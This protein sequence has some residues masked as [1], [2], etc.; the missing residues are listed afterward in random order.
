[1]TQEDDQWA[2]G[3]FGT[4]ITVMMVFVGLGAAY[5]AV[6]AIVDI[7]IRSVGNKYLP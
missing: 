2:S 1:M 6:N 7:G 5:I 3:A 4:G